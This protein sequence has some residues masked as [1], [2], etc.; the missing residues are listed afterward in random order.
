MSK[1]TALSDRMKRYE[2]SSKDYLPLKT[3]AIIRVDGRAFHTFTRGFKKPFDAILMDCMQKTMKALCEEIQGCVLGYTQ[4]DEI[5]LVLIDY[6]SHETAA[7]FD[8][9]VQKCSSIAA[10]K[11]TKHFNRF[12]YEAVT[13]YDE[14][15][16]EAWNVSDEDKKYITALLKARDMGA[17]FDARIFS[18]PQSEVCNYIFWRQDDATRNSIQMAGHA[19][20]SKNEMHRKSNNQVQ[21]MLF[22]QKNINW[23]DYPVPQKRGTCC[24]KE[25]AIIERDGEKII[26]KKWKLD[27]N[28]PIFTGDDRKYVEDQILINRK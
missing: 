4:S 21:D 2:L 28:I 14:E 25:D 5:S 3:P 17:E 15:M 26:R 7:W 19:Y 6:Q 11:A 20:F 13:K 12:F 16:Y 18:M 23:N 1:T 22:L 10:S 27:M 24:I 8:Y 9:C